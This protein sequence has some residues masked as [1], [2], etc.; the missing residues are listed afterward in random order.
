MGE[1]EEMLVERTE[2]GVTIVAVN[3]EGGRGWRRCERS[4][5]AF[6]FPLHSHKTMERKK[7]PL[8]NK[9]NF[10]ETLLSAHSVFHETFGICFY[11][12]WLAVCCVL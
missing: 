7:S 9:N 12:F 10:A 1:K 8:E 6:S 5:F 4:L 2:G 11:L 3:C